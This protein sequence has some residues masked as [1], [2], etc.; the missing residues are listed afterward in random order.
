MMLGKIITA[1]AAAAALILIAMAVLAHGEFRCGQQ[2]YLT[3]TGGDCC[4]N[5]DCV[6]VPN[7]IAWAARVGTPIDLDL[8]GTRRSVVVNIVHPSCDDHGRSWGCP[9]G[10]LFRAIGG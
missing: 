2:T 1:L 9:S 6:P 8:R 4:N 7:E 5:L 10:C 3:A